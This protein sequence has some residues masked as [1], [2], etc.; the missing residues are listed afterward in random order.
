MQH[1][2]QVCESTLTVA[3][4][5]KYGWLTKDEYQYEVCLNQLKCN[6]STQIQKQNINQYGKP[7]IRTK[8]GTS[9]QE[10]LQISNQSSQYLWLRYWE[11]Q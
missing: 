5:H 9:N 3:M 4:I 6:S 1:S 11:E 2:S 7:K 10:A 8:C